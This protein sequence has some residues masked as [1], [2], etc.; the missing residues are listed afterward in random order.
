MRFAVAFAS[1]ALLWIA[2]APAYAHLF[3]A[4]ARP[5][6]PWIES[7]KGTHYLVEGT[8]IV[9]ERP[10]LM[11]QPE[12][13]TAIRQPL[14]DTSGDYNVALLAALLLATPG[15]SWRQL[16]RTLAWSL[17]LLVVTQLLSFLVTIEYTKLW[18]TKTEAGIVLST[19]YSR[20]KLILFDWLYAFFEFM[21]RGFFALI[22]YLGALAF[23]W[24]RPSEPPPAHAVG[25][26]APCPC[27]SGLKA[28]RCCAA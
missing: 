11:R 20:A 25:R 22:I 17:G 27:G 4:M 12:E 24:G 13:V 15:W 10:I 6:I 2:F 9:A 28:K 16:S 1:L 23:L 26:N 18:P 5:L 19:D 7:V 3:T 8:K 21:G 14:R